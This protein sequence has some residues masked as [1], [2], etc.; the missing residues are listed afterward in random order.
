M[1]RYALQKVEPLLAEQEA[2]LTAVSGGD[3]QVVSGQDG[4][5]ALQLAL[6]L[7]DS[8]QTHRPVEFKAP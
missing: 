4:L 6:S 8:G 3:A 5:I 7:I 2:F 1:T